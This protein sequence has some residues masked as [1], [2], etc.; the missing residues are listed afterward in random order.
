M[1]TPKRLFLSLFLLLASLTV[2][3]QP[4]PAFEAEIRAFEAQD[5]ASPPPR[6]GIVFVGSSSIRLWQDLATDFP[7][8]PVL[9]RGFG[10]SHLTDVIQYAHRMIL[11][12][13][14]RQ[15]VIYAGENDIATGTVTAQETFDRFVTLFRRIRDA[16]PQT[17][18]TFIAI[19]PSPSR[20]HYQPVVQEAN[21]QIAA[22]LSKQKRAAF[23][24]VY[25][26]MLT[27]AGQMRGELFRS[28]SLHM[29]RRGY[30]LWRDRL[31]PY[32]R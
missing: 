15:V 18:V 20:R 6:N 28:D 1:Q 8:K 13:R 12:Y 23:V 19:K 27:P 17:H 32:L 31:R 26:P 3:A 16:L 21:A 25:S 22:F 24:D 5:A 10:G 7:G 2:P 29:N 30:D 4:A 11:P 9:N 14:P